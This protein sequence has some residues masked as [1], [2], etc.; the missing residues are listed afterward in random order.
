MTNQS[1]SNV[2]LPF[3]TR[4]LISYNLTSYNKENII[5]P[6]K[7]NLC[8]K[9]NIISKKWIELIKHVERNSCLYNKKMREFKTVD[10]REVWAQIDAALTNKKRVSTII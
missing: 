2:C 4:K 6:S 8:W 9:W 10:K 3:L 1:K 7:S 5:V